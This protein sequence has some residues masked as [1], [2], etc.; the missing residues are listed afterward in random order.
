MHTLA[1]H[2][3]NGRMDKLLCVHRPYNFSVCMGIEA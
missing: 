1:V 2:G 3:Y